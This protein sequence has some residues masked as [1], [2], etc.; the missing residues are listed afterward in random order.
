MNTYDLWIYPDQ[1]PQ[2]LPVAFLA[3]RK[4]TG[5]TL[6]QLNEGAS[7]LWFPNHQDIALRS[8]GG[9]VTP[10]YWNFAMFKVFQRRFADPFLLEPFLY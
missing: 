9:L 6:R 3:P 8:D 2:E 7:M 5:K 10:D 1:E 4:L